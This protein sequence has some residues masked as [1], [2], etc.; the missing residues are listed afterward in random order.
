MYFALLHLFA[1][2]ML[3]TVLANNSLLLW[4]ALEGTTLSSTFLVGLYRKRS[5]VEAAWKYIIICSTGIS[6]GLLG[7]LL[8]GYG[9]SL[10]GTLGADIFTLTGLI[11]NAHLISPEIARWSFVFLFVGFGAFKCA[12]SNLGAFFWNFAEYCA[13]WNHSFPIYH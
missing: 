9:A 8:F 13:L 7:I 5:S 4:I 3:V 10:G 6:L 12:F 2:C 1:L 11:Q